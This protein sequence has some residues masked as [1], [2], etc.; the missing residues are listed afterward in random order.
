MTLIPKKGDTA[1]EFG[2]S[3]FKGQR[4]VELILGAHTCPVFSEGTVRL[5]E[6]YD[7]YKNRIHC[8]VWCRTL[9]NRRMV[10]M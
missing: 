4:P 6:I 8:C 5:K 3:D 10:V 7:I 9:S 1:S 2:L